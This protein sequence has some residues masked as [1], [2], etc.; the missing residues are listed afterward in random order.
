LEIA[1]KPAELQERVKRTRGNL[2]D[3]EPTSGKKRKL[4]D[5]DRIP[6]SERKVQAI[7]QQ[8]PLRPHVTPLEDPG[9]LNALS[10]FPPSLSTFS[11]KIAASPKLEPQVEPVGGRVSDK[12]RNAEL[13]GLIPAI[14]SV[15]TQDSYVRDGDNS[16]TPAPAVIQFLPGALNQLKTAPLRSKKIPTHTRFSSPEPIPSTMI[17]DIDDKESNEQPAL[18]QNKTTPRKPIKKQRSNTPNTSLKSLKKLKKKLKKKRTRTLAD[19]S[20]KATRKSKKR[21]SLT[22]VA[23]PMKSIKKTRKER[24]VIP[25]DVQ[26]EPVKPPRNVDPVYLAYMKNE[27]KKFSGEDF[28]KRYPSAK[29][30]MSSAGGIYKIKIEYDENAPIITV[31]DVPVNSDDQ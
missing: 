7:R 24:S 8:V 3:Q 9:R 15:K 28:V 17:I 21:N 5:P 29:A 6:V 4:S 27:R 20:P 12:Y 2:I 22:V 18:F 30:L 31:N 25:V 13:E 26:T 10:K 14:A 11:D 19:A 23:A 1:P 16:Q